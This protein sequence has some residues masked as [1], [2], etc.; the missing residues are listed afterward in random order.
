MRLRQLTLLLGLAG[1]SV[2]GLM[3]SRLEVVQ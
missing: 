2:V 3:H 1:T